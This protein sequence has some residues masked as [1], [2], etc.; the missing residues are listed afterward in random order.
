MRFF[1]GSPVSIHGG[2]WDGKVP[3]E[4]QLT[5]GGG[6]SVLVVSAMIRVPVRAGIRSIGAQGVLIV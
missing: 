2:G 5:T 4:G 3:Q 1:S 6:S